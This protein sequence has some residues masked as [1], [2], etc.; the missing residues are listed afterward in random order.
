MTKLYVRTGVRLRCCLGV[1]LFPAVMPALLLWY[2]VVALWGSVR[3]LGDRLR[4]WL[5]DCRDEMV[6]AWYV[7]AAALTG[8]DLIKERYQREV[9]RARDAMFPNRK[10]AE[11]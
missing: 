1:L 8:R 4:R 3:D 10:R 5:A 7:I 11:Q 9:E 2:L 6:G